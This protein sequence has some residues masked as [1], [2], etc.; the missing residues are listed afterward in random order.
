MTVVVFAS[1]LAALSAQ[2]PVRDGGATPVSVGTGYVAGIVRDDGGRPLRSAMVTISGEMS[3]QRAAITNGDGQFVFADLPAGRFTITASKPGYPSMSFGGTRPNRPGAGVMLGD[4]QQVT[5]ADIV[6]P[7]GAVLTGTVFDESGQPMPGVPVMPWEVRTTLAGERTL[8]FPSTGGVSTATD[9]RG[10][11]R[12]YGLPPG[13]Y[14]VGTS[15]A[16]GGHG[17]A[18]RVPTDAEIQAAFAAAVNPAAAGIAPRAPT[19]STQASTYN[20]ARVFHPGAIDPM[21]ATTVRL[22]AG[23][24][25]GG[26]DLHMQ[27]RPMPAL[28]IFVTR[29][30]G[31]AAGAYLS[32]ARTGSVAALNSVIVT[33]AMRPDGRSVQYLGAGT[34]VVRVT[35]SGANGQPRVW[36]MQEVR[37]ENEPVTVTLE[38]QP[39]MTATGRLLIE[40]TS[41]PAP[42]WSSVRVALQNLTPGAPET[43]EAIIDADGRFTQNALSPGRFRVTASVAGAAAPAWTLKSVTI[44]ERDVTDMPFD[45]Q[46]G[47]APVFVVTLTDRTSRLSG[48]LIDPRGQPSTGYFVVVIPADRRYWLPQTRRIASAR[49]DAKGQFLFRNLPPGE[50]RIAATTDLVPADLRDGTALE[51]LLPHSLPATVALGEN[52]S[53]DLHVAGPRQ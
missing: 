36:A 14:T 50:Y 34:Y 25:R 29:P 26:L 1:A 43:I 47:E 23:E 42:S 44:G 20:Y 51:A 40:A 39:A 46:A 52:R 41:Q 49:P 37:I 32:V 48:S 7:R 2:A 45:V 16:F 18:A 21:A 15:W 4:G 53:I 38:L 28:E 22:A 11:F 3:F 30:G 27:F 6:M 31:S 10:Q 35:A 13:E 12:F 33:P 24:E 9:D 8:E 19:S 17:G 5:G